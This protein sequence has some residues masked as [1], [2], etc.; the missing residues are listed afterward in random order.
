MRH[1]L[2]NGLDLF[3]CQSYQRANGALPAAGRII[4]T[5]PQLSRFWSTAFPGTARSGDATTRSSLRNLWDKLLDIALTADDSSRRSLSPLLHQA[6][7]IVKRFA[8]GA[9]CLY[10]AAYDVKHHV[11]EF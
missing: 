3:R 1:W 10:A 11:S 2:S 9:L 6:Y 8:G 7:L 5:V 4:G